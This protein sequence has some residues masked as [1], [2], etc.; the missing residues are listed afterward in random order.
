MIGFNSGGLQSPDFIKIEHVIFDI[1]HTTI[2]CCCCVQ[3]VIKHVIPYD[4]HNVCF[5]IAWN[6][7]YLTGKHGYL[8]LNISKGTS[9][10][11]TGFWVIGMQSQNI[12]KY[13]PKVNFEISHTLESSILLSY[14]KDFVQKQC[15]HVK[16]DLC[17]AKIPILCTDSQILRVF[18][19][20]STF[21]QPDMT[22]SMK[23]LYL[24]NAMSNFKFFAP[25]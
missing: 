2:G 15:L 10:R 13:S 4:T 8:W 21:H 24:K 16:T 5:K 3:P 1:F 25:K 14:L 12:S 20:K 9:C 23:L 7:T 17:I 11:K 22:S 6:L 18:F 19:S